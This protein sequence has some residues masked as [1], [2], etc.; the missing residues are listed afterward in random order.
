ME[1]TNEVL[2]EGS[3]PT[4]PDT[5]QQPETEGENQNDSSEAEGNEAEGENTE[6]AENEGD[7]NHTDTGETAA[8]FM[9][10]RYNHE[11]RAL[12]EDE[13]RQFAQIGIQY[14]NTKKGIFS[15]LDYAAALKGVS[16]DKLVEEMISIPEKEQREKLMEMYGDDEESVEIGMRIYREKQQ[17]DYQK[18]LDARADEAQKAEEQNKEKISSRLADE[19]ISLKAEIPEVPEYEKLP[20]SVIRDAASGKRDLLSAYLLWLRKQE[21]QIDAAKKTEEAASTA[22]AGQMK[23]QE[24][25][26]NALGDV[27]SAGV[28]GK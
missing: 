1:E 22:S 10:V 23:T 3:E 21:K 20:D 25:N 26:S 2:T 4:T 5:E 19:Y 12:S 17:A 14:E 8:P 13:A 11:D 15:K 27:F 24:N 6:A 16:V 18:V 9:T 7:G 28:W